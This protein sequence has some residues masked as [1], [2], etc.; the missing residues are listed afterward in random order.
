MKRYLVTSLLLIILLVNT[1]A[2]AQTRTK[3]KVD[4]SKAMKRNPQP[5][6]VPPEKPLQQTTMDTL[7]AVNKAYY[8]SAVRRSEYQ[9]RGAEDRRSP[10]YDP[11]V[12]PGKRV[13]ANEPQP[14]IQTK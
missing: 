11:N 6:V 3:T 12:I 13:P 4:T 2:I 7:P 1:N 8:D 10:T 14:P 9:N 5:F